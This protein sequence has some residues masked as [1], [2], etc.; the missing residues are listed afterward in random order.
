MGLCMDL[1]E[2][3]V[4]IKFYRIPSDPVKFLVEEGVSNSRG[5]DKVKSHR[6]CNFQYLRVYGGSA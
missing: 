2:E 4:A 3:F 6:Q 1:I 5:G